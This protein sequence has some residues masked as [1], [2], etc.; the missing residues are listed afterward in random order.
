MRDFFVWMSETP[1]SIALR[2][3]FY[4]WPMLEASHVM[5]LMLFVGTIVMVDVR[6]LGLGFKSVA[7]SEFDKR[8]LPLTVIG[9]LLL[10]VTGLLLFYAKPLD[11][12]HSLFFRLKMLIILVAF[13]NIAIFH[14]RVQRDQDKWDLED[15]PP[16]SARISA[17]I[18][19]SSWV[20]VVIVGRMI[21]Y[22]FYNCP[23]LEPGGLLSTLADCPVIETA[24]RTE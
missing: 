2:E 1:W 4:V 9:F 5:S 3:S 19:L 13:I 12:Y 24:E 16:A 23:K 15:K 7:V 22:D 14:F 10:L 21:A 11:Y 20:F 6:L 8:I 17:V 18:S